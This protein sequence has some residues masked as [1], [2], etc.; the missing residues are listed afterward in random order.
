[1][2][3]NEDEDFYNNE[4]DINNDILNISQR[5]KSKEDIDIYNTYIN[6]QNG[7]INNVNKKFNHHSLNNENRIH[8]FDKGHP[9]QNPGNIIHNTN[10]FANKN[11]FQQ[12]LINTDTN[13]SSNFIWS[14]LNF[15]IL[16][17]SLSEYTLGFMIISYLYF[18]FIGKTFNDKYATIWFDANSQYFESKFERLG[19]KPEVETIKNNTEMIK[20]A[21]NVYKYY[22]E[23]YANIEN[24]TA[25][26]EFRRFQS[27]TSLVSSLFFNITD[28]VYYKVSISPQEK[29]PNVFCICR[30]SDKKNLL[31]S[32]SDIVRIKNKYNILI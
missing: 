18:N 29:V 4:E 5:I 19:V 27:T 15:R 24:V 30:K 1:M 21:Y 9:G 6:H 14:I 10:K 20:E 8:N 32:Y 16:W 12:N 25:I 3:N 23:K 26:L 31:K 13:S 11:N 22:A 17:F 2:I 7:G 28:K